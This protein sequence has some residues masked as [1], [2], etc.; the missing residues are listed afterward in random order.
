MRKVLCTV[1]AAQIGDDHKKA[2]ESSLRS[3]YAKCLTANEKLLIIWCE[4]PSD[5]GYTS[6]EQ[7][8]VSLVVIE[9]QDGLNQ[10]VREDMLA[11]CAADWSKI[12][13]IA[14]ERL[15]ISVF[16]ASQ[17]A[18]YMLANQR[19]MSLPGRIRF[20]L[21]MGTSLLRS[22]SSRG[23]LVFSPNLGA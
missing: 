20:A 16:D 18:D 1:N 7:P 3:N 4:L 14:L 8:C 11:A 2:L 13:G 6:Y 17:F 21:H 10:A 15:M 22:K 12:C 23:L 9:A 5:Q 19:R